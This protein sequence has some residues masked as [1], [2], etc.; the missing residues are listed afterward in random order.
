VEG[1]TRQNHREE[2]TV[3]EPTA[4]RA[5]DEGPATYQQLLA[6]AVEV[7][8]QAARLTRTSRDGQPTTDRWDWGE[9]VCL[10]VAGA[11]ANIGS[12]DEALGGRPGSWE[13][14]CVRNMLSAT[15]GPG[16]Q[17]LLRHRT[18]P[19]VVDVYV[20]EILTDVGLTDG[21]DEA[22][23]ALSD[24]HALR[25]PAA[26]ADEQAARELALDA[27]LA[28]LSRQ[29]AADWRDYGDALVGHIQASAAQLDGLAVRVVVNVDLHTFR[30]YLP[31]R[32][33]RVALATQLL[34]HALDDVPVPGGGRP[35]VDRLLDSLGPVA[36]PTPCSPRPTPTGVVRR[37]SL[38]PTPSPDV[39]MGR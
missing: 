9:F 38:P 22:E 20:E 27:L 28:H 12:T 8:T 4:P 35:P 7:L 26:T 18:E 31:G 19:I 10:A 23:I 15:V 3:P 2:R 17:H 13:A 37:P 34:D 36:E 29:R 6:N 21:Y 11:A 16:D 30:T 33:T 24:A 1:H 32:D 25:T 5:I 14:G 39:G